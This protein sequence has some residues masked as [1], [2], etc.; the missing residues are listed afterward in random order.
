MLDLRVGELCGIKHQDVHLSEAISCT[1][2]TRP[3]VHLFHRDSN[4]NGA[5]AKTA[6]APKLRADRVQ[7]GERRLVS[8]AMEEALIDYLGELST[9]GHSDFVLV[10]TCGSRIGEGMTTEGVRRLVARI[11]KRA[12]L[13]RLRPHQFRHRFATDL[14]NASGGDAEVARYAGGWS[15]TAMVEQ[16]YGHVDAPNG[17]MSN[18]LEE[19]WGR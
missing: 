4:P 18:A 7:G 9:P 1:E 19:V 13:P 2:E 17:R 5:R 3:H 12:G 10:N 16:V 14:L 15:S 8:P 6:T 11:G